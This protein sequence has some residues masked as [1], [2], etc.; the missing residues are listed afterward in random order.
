MDL[1]W[2][3]DNPVLPCNR[4]VAEARLQYLKKR[5]CRDPK[6][7]VKYRA[8]IQECVDKGYARKLSK[9]ETVTV[10]N[11]TLYLPN[12]PVTNPNNPGK[13]RVVF[14]TAGKFNGMSF[15]YQLLQGPSLTNDLTGVLIRLR[16][17]QVA[18]SADI[19]G[20]LYQANVTSR[21]TDS[22]RFLW[23]PDSID[24]PPEDYKMLD[25]IFGAK[26]LFCQGT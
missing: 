1:L 7:E 15:N 20:M 3:D 2:K 21:D 6:L 18:F 23:W 17:E 22:L 13:V 12:H 26:S 25:N 11:T 4:A 5:F 8:A 24:D 19:E 14:D 10:S 9:E 16:E